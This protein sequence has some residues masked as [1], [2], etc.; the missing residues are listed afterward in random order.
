M[1]DSN[2]LVIGSKPGSKLPKISVDKI[3]TANGAAERA[4]HYRR[5]Y[6]KNELTCIVVAREFNKN[7]YVR[8][9]IIRAKPKRI[10]IRSGTI[11]LPIELKEQT[12]LTYLSNYA[13]WVYQSKFFKYKKISLLLS[14]IFHQ[15]KF[16]DKFL[17]IVKLIKNNYI[18]GVSSGFYAILVSLEE[19]PKSNII[20]SG[21][22][23]NGGKQFYKSKRSNFFTY[24]S[25]AR[26]DRFL[27]KRLLKKFKKRLYTLDSD[28]A[29]IASIKQWEGNS[30]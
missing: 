2:I 12:N 16:V 14:E 30:F 19:N 11:H 9:R 1:K 29:E 7:E 24:D 22:G 21:I 13:Q 18:Q 20:I 15:K 5:N 28:L 25:R 27:I 6:L 4:T 23:M 8:G 17:H 10:I 3:Y 26:V